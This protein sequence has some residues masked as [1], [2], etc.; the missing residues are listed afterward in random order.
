MQAWSFAAQGCSQAL[1]DRI[2]R[3]GGKGIEV[4][5]SVRANQAKLV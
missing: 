4:A 3:C 1:S 2:D 5:H